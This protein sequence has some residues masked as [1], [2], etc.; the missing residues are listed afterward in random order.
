ML[1]RWLVVFSL[2]CILAGS[3]IGSPVVSSN[4]PGRVYL[5]VHSPIHTAISLPKNPTANIPTESIGSRRSSLTP[6]ELQFVLG[7]GRS[8]DSVTKA[9]RIVPRWSGDRRNNFLLSVMKHNESI[10]RTNKSSVLLYSR[11]R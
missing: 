8:Y 10:N 5:Q 6:G 11:E 4:S 3:V 1:F 2:L 7:G 9:W